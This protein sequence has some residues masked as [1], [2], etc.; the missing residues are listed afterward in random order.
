[1]YLYVEMSEGTRSSSQLVVLL[2]HM[3][4]CSQLFVTWQL[5]HVAV[6]LRS[7]SYGVDVVPGQATLQTVRIATAGDQTSAQALRA[8][9]MVL[10][11]G[12][13]GGEQ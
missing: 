5:F 6:T 7:L 1:M 12:G 11:A 3:L 8:V 10:C 2:P 9:P 13:G 4:G